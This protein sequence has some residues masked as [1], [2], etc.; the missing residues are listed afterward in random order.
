MEVAG[1]VLTVYPV[2][3][4]A[5]EQY[6][7]GAKYFSHYK[8]FRQKYEAFIRDMEGQ[9]LFFEGILQDLM[10]GGP[11]PF[12]AGA[13]SKDAFLEIVNDATFTGWRDPILRKRLESRLDIRYDWCIH[14]IKRIYDILEELGKL[15]DIQALQASDQT[16]DW[17][18]YQWKRITQTLF[19]E[20]Y[21]DH[22]EAKRLIDELKQMVEL[23][24]KQ[25]VQGSTRTTSSFTPFFKK[26]RQNAN[27]LH[28]VLKNGWNCHCIDSHKAMLRLERR[29]E[30]V[31]DDFKLLLNLATLAEESKATERAKQR[32]V[33]VRI[34]KPEPDIPSL[35]V[36]SSASDSAV[37]LASTSEVSISKVAPSLQSSSR[38]SVA[39]DP[40]IP[41][42]QAGKSIDKVS[43]QVKATGLTGLSSRFK[44][45][46]R[47][48]K[49]NGNLLRTTSAPAVKTIKHFTV[50]EGMQY[51][52]RL[53]EEQSIKSAKSAKFDVSTVS[54]ESRC[55]E[56][57]PMKD[58][59]IPE[60]VLIEN[61]CHA[62]QDPL[63]GKSLGCLIDEKENRHEFISNDFPRT[64][65]QN[66]DIITLEEV[67]KEDAMKIH[68]FPPEKRAHV[69]TILAS[70]LLQLQRT[71]WLKD[72]WTKRDIFFVT[73]DSK[74]IF[75]QPYLSQ[76]FLSLKS[77]SEGTSSPPPNP[78]PPPHFQTKTSL[79]SLGILLI[80]LCFGT[81]IE[82]HQH[83]V[84]LRPLSPNS[85]PNH[86]FNLAIAH[87]WT[88][89]EIWAENSLYPDPITSCLSFPHLLG[90][91]RE[92]RLD[93]VVHDMYVLI[94]KPLYDDMVV[95][96]PPRKHMSNG[97]EY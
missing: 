69:A 90:R 37:D 41:T 72:N 81:H 2:T 57:L 53:D 68:R 39:S 50:L 38:S 10:C 52:G 3:I 62:I 14:T 70:S 86:A 12:L 80:E 76:D 61:L 83:K 91:E 49:T 28:G 19:I 47:S 54:I 4:L 23:S 7:K 5:F 93:E 35:G 15:L 82:S 26:I 55:P 34:S 73:R 32:S 77:H 25:R 29:V 89:E 21:D 46:F 88:W 48:K 20:R 67:L 17:W 75:D 79:E 16:P 11:D 27:S 71:H 97:G 22:K 6:K 87:A 36:P 33:A 30:G 60:N 94:A 58:P 85:Q 8:R 74:P 84:Q 96:W 92:G 18:R 78:A 63:P 66:E 59:I 1:F 9:Q 65:S 56:V 95:R 13:G 51:Q 24:D 44:N 45:K 64:T 42:V 31:D 40:S 43:L